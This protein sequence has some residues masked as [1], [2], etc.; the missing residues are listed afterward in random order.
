MAVMGILIMAGK[1]FRAE[2]KGSTTAY[3]KLTSSVRFASGV[4]EIDT[5]PL[6]TKIRLPVLPNKI[7]SFITAPSAAKILMCL[8]V[9]PSMSDN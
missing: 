8:G 5:A 2:I 7:S 1:E 9:L 4:S 3:V 6:L